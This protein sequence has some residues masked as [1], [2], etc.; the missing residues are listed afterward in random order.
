MERREVSC[1]VTFWKSSET[2]TQRN[3]KRGTEG[4]ED[5]PPGGQRR[6]ILNLQNGRKKPARGFASS[7]NWSFNLKVML[8]LSVRTS[9]GLKC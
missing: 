2:N 5:Q 1:P 6:R 3:D 8:V 7:E 4:R 9:G